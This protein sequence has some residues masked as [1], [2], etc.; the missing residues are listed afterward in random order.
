MQIE[1]FHDPTTSTLSYVAWDRD[2]RAGVLIDPVCDYAP[3]S[4]RLSTRSAEAIAR[5]LDAERIELHYVLDTH[6]HADHVT[7]MPF[8]RSRFGARTVIG[9]EIARVQRRF[10]EFLQLGDD[11]P[12]DGR[13][14]DQL[15]G[16]GERLEAG[17]LTLEC[18]HT[19][20]HTPACMTYRIGDALFVGDTLFQP[21]YGTARCDFPGGSAG[22]LFDSIAR[23]YDLP[24][25]LRV[26][27]GHDYR[28]GGRPVGYTQP[29]GCSS[30]RVCRTA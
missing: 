16:D 10:A 6:V 21:D 29:A 14:F 11:F 25:T 13:Q 9:G 1:A 24:E 8:F 22:S 30:R 15:V 18:L 23:L 5:F 17:P 3:A 28:P 2:A 7:A 19:P 27:T 4:A 12:T 26:F 20:G